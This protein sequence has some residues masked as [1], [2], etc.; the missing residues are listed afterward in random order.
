M[1]AAIRLGVTGSEG[2]GE[3]LKVGGHEDAPDVGAE[4]LIAFPATGSHRQAALE[5]EDQGFDARPK[6]VQFPSI[7]RRASSVLLDLLDGSDPQTLC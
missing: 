7:V 5:P 6:A 2:R 1:A 4:A 3:R